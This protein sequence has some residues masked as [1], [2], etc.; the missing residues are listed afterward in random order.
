MGPRHRERRRHPRR[1]QHG[2]NGRLGAHVRDD[3]NDDGAPR[4]VPDRHDGRMPV[5][6]WLLVALLLLVVLAPA[7]DA[8][9][10]CTAAEVMAGCGGSCTAN[11]TATACTITRTVSVTPPGAGSVCTFDFGTREV[12]LGQPG[13]NGNFIGRPTASA[14]R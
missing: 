14:S 9:A 13:A 6:R 8:A 12:T 3:E 4:P 1:R 7:R 10:V 2:P 5:S 11:C